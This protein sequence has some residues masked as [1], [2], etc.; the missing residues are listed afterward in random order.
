MRLREQGCLETLVS[1]S[2]LIDR[3]NKAREQGNYI[4]RENG[5]HRT[6]GKGNHK[7]NGKE[8]DNIT[9]D[10]LAGLAEKGDETSLELLFESARYLGIAISNLVNILNPDKVVIGR[11]F[12]RYA[13][14]V[15]EQILQIVQDKALEVPSSHVRITASSL[16]DRSSALGAAIIPVKYCLEKT[17]HLRKP[18][19]QKLI[20][21]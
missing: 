12:T 18:M 14:I 1:A 4:A 13:H 6:G 11:D 20:K 8:N 3:F 7:A 17:N 2:A 15:M 10:E 16:G 9:L 5:S 21:S 19:N